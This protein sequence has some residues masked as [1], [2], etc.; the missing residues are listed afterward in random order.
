MA[1]ARLRPPTRPNPIWDFLPARPWLPLGAEHGAAGGGGQEKDAGSTL[2]YAR[3]FLK[4]R[5]NQPALIEGD[6]DLLDAPDPVIAFKRGGAVLC[7][8]N[9]QRF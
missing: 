3:A 6:L 5:K 9:H 4:A 8:F 1:A 2:G 7:V